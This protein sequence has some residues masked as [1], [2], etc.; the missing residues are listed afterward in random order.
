MSYNWTLD[1][2][3]LRASLIY[4]LYSVR[5]KRALIIRS[6]QRARARNATQHTRHAMQP[7]HTARVRN[8]ET[9]QE[10]LAVDEAKSRESTGHSANEAR[11]PAE[12]NKISGSSHSDTAGES[13]VLDDFH[14]DAFAVE[15]GDRDSDEGGRAEGE[16]RVDDDTMLGGTLGVGSVKGRPVPHE[17]NGNK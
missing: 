1:P 5:R 6:R 17:K 9:H 7:G 13:G 15:V 16:D 11:A 2:M 12:E 14:G 10:G 8:A 3:G 4:C